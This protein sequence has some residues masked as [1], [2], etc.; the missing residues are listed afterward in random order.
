VREARLDV[1]RRIQAFDLQSVERQVQAGEVVLELLQPPRTDDRDDRHGSLPEP[2]QG[3]LGR[4]PTDLARN[5]PDLGDDRLGTLVG[6]VVTFHHLA[7][8][9]RRIISV[10]NWCQFCF[11]L[12]TELTPIVFFF[13][14]QKD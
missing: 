12:K 7:V 6:P 3:D 9:P 11:S 5:G 14:R 13:R 1:A 2:R 4:R 8:H 10:D